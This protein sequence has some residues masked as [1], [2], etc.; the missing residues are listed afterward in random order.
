MIIIVTKSFCLIDSSSDNN[1]VSSS[2][3]N[4]SSSDNNVS[5]SDNNVSSS[6]IFEKLSS[7]FLL[8]LL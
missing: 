2:D 7:L 4:V 5:S 1:G 6:L 3:N 8:L